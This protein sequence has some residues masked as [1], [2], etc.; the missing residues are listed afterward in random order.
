MQNP[1]NAIPPE[2]RKNYTDA[3]EGNDLEWIE[4]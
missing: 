3:P 2:Q 4:E 1:Q